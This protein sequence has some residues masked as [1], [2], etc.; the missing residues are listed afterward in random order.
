MTPDS[1]NVPK[2]DAVACEQMYLEVNKLC[3]TKL[4]EFM[5]KMKG[6][7]DYGPKLKWVQGELYIWKMRAARFNV[8]SNP[9]SLITLLEEFR[10]WDPVAEVPK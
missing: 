10:K 7:R 9:E 3:L 5:V 6:D 4:E 1:L 2:L 8:A